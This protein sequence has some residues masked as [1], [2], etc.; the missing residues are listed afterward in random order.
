MSGYWILW[1]V[2]SGRQAFAPLHIC[3]PAGLFGTGIKQ[4][5]QA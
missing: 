3:R 2:F 4:K 1:A 5:S